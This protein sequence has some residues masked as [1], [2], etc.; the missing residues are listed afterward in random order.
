MQIQANR[1]AKDE[2]SIKWLDAPVLED[3][4]VVNLGDCLEYWTNNLLK[5]TK[6]RVIFTPETQLTPRYS[7]AYFCQGSQA[8]LEPV[9]SK[10]IRASV[11]KDVVDAQN[12]PLTAADHL[13]MRL[14]ATYSHY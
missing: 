8:L 11:P 10:Y 14:K 13:Q 3:C 6:H 4:I 2:E 9:P 5:S 7:M 12:K 1:D